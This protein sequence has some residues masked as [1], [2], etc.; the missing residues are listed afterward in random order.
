M[1]YRGEVGRAIGLAS[2]VTDEA[3]KQEAWLDLCDIAIAS[4]V[5]YDIVQFYSAAVGQL[6]RCIE[7]ATALG[8]EPRRALLC[9][10]LGRLLT[11]KG[12]F[13]EADVALKESEVIAR[14]LDLKKPLIA[15]Q[16]AR[17]LW[18][19]DSGASAMEAV[20]TLTA[21]A[22]ELRAFDELALVTKIDRADPQLPP[23]L[24]KGRQPMLCRVL[25]DLTA[26]AL[27]VGDGK[28]ISASLDQLDELTVE[29]FPGYVPH[30]YFVYAQCL[31]R[32]EPSQPEKA[33]DLIHR[34]REIGEK[35]QNPWVAQYA[36]VLKQKLG[37]IE[38]TPARRRGR[39][40][41]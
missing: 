13:A 6:Q 15:A 32:S 26:A 12:Q 7:S 27:S 10:H 24:L 2:A 38:S 16:A 25:L 28:V 22:D 39:K 36:D 9:A 35:S 41:R 34:A 18:L 5:I 30:Y 21:V 4:V 37:E 23:T 14:R 20:Q 40:K 19:L 3:I 33:R 29:H 1:A 8:D 11:Y 31:L 17:G